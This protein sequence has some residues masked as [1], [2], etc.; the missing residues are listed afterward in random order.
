MVI[1]SK[2]AHTRPILTLTAWTIKVKR[3]KVG[4]PSLETHF[5]NT[6]SN[7]KLARPY[8]VLNLMTV[9]HTWLVVEF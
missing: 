4:V 7:A 8:C 9:V 2:S 6:T 3:E 1:S 5:I